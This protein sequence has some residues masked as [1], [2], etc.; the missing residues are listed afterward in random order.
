MCKRLAEV[1]SQVRFKPS[2]PAHLSNRNMTSQLL[3]CQ[4]VT[5]NILMVGFGGKRSFNANDRE[6]ITLK[7]SFI[8][9]VLLR[10]YWSLFH[11]V[12]PPALQQTANYPGA[13]LIGR[14]GV[15]VKKEKF[16][17]VF[18]FFKVP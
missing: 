7:Y 4:S 5:Q 15:Q 6:N 2:L 18:M 16:T 11:L 12:Q 3:D 9:F 8:S 14:S 10:D 13:K 1:R 17:G